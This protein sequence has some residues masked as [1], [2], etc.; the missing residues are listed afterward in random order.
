MSYLMVIGVGPVQ[1]FIASA[2]RSRDLWFGSWLLSEISKAAAKTIRGHEG[3]ELIFPDIDKTE[4][5]EPVAYLKGKQ[6]SGTEFNVVNKIVALISANPS[7]LG[8][9]IDKAM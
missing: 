1:E 7:S 6:V 9:E 5:L 2:R 3:C 4:D 8:D